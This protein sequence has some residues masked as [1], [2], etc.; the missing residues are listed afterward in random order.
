MTVSS[1]KA[2]R[3]ATVGN[4]FRNLDLSWR[5]EE[6]LRWTV[7]LVMACSDTFKYLDFTCELAGASYSAS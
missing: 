5:D 2:I 7:K 3:E 4:A 1:S 6:D